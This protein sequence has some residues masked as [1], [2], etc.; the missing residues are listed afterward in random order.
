LIRPDRIVDAFLGA[1]GKSLGALFDAARDVKDGGEGPVLLFF[2]EFEA[3]AAKRKP[4]GRDAQREMNSVVD[5]LLQRFDAH[6]GFI[7]AATNHGDELDPAIWRRFDLQIKI[8]SP[9]QSERERILAEARRMTTAMPG[10]DR[11]QS[12]PIE[13]FT[14]VATASPDRRPAFRAASV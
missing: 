4:G 6:S 10:Y 8:D 1:T 5:V 13:R 12:L 11:G 14:K 3:L 2:D 9:G 7:I